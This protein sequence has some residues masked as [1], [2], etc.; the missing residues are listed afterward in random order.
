MHFS[1]LLLTTA[2]ATLASAAQFCAETARP[3]G[4]PQANV[5]ADGGEFDINLGESARGNPVTGFHVRTKPYTNY[6]DFEFEDINATTWDMR[7]FSYHNERI[8]ACYNLA[9]PDLCFF[10]NAD[11]V[12][13][14]EVHDGIPKV[15]EDIS[16]FLA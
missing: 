11:D 6:A 15:R 14:M 8:I 10:L 4:D 5:E 9:E 16:I 12:C 3:A 13:K 7:A 1:T 2:A